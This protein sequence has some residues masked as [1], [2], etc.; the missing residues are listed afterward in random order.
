MI[1]SLEC[2]L[3]LSITKRVN[4]ETTKSDYLIHDPISVVQH[5]REKKRNILYALLF[6]A[7]LLSRYEILFLQR[8][9]RL[10]ANAQRLGAAAAFTTFHAGYKR[11]CSHYLFRGVTAAVAPNRLLCVRHLYKFWVMN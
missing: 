1:M 5:S 9:R 2:I 3:K 11:S 4:M 6:L 7:T 10:A 8:S